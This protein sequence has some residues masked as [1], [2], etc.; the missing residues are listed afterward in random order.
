MRRLELEEAAVDVR[1][2]NVAYALRDF[3]HEDVGIE[4]QAPTEGALLGVFDREC[5][6]GLGQGD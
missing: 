1:R 3:L 6:D 4:V 2:S 5:P